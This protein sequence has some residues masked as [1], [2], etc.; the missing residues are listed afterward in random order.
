MLEKTKVKF[1]ADI[2]EASVGAI[3]LAEGCMKIASKSAN[4][5]ISSE[6]IDTVNSPPFLENART[7]VQNVFNSKPYTKDW[8]ILHE[9]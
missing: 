7:S 1:F 2:L 3:L 4:L 9:M 5:F 8:K 6:M